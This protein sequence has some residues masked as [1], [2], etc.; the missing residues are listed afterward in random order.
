MLY[1]VFVVGYMNLSLL[2]FLLVFNLFH[3]FHL[4]S[5]RFVSLV[6]GACPNG[7]TIGQP[8]EAKGNC[9][10]LTK[11]EMIKKERTAKLSTCLLLLQAKMGFVWK[12]VI[13][14]TS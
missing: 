11:K 13:G 6:L 8:C 3:F 2:C 12:I 4:P 5:I 7:R 1:I 14:R 9:K 10:S